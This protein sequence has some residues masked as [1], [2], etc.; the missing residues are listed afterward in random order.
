MVEG[1][2]EVIFGDGGCLGDG[3]VEGEVGG[4]GGGEGAAGAVGS[5]GWEARCGELVGGAV[6]GED[7]GALGAGEVAAF[8]EDGAVVLFGKLEG[9]GF[10]FV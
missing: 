9:G 6:F 10:H 7:V 3:V 1:L 8:E 4:D 5:E 2:V